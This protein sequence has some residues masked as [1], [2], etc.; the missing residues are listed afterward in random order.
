MINIIRKL[1]VDIIERIDEGNSN[2]T[3]EDEVKIISMLRKY[4]KK[5]VIMSKYLACE[6]LGISRASFDA[7][8]KEGK[9]PKGKKQAG[10]KELQWYKKDID[11]YQQS[12]NITKRKHE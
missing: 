12:K 3:E 10:F 11:K 1:L 8:V 4:T 9:I 7:L 2:I 5:D 6:Y